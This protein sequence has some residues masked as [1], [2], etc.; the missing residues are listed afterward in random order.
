MTPEEIAEEE[1]RA[2]AHL[3]TAVPYLRAVYNGDGFTTEERD[4]LLQLTGSG[5][6]YGIVLGL[7]AV[8]GKTELSFDALIPDD[9]SDLL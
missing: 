9:A 7:R 6:I 5:M 8:Q 4:L 2:T 1:E 3:M